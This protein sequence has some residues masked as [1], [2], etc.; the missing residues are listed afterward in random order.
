MHL[1]LLV[2][3]IVG[4]P[5]YV[6][7]AIG[8]FWTG[9]W[10]W[11]DVLITVVLFLFLIRHLGREFFD[12]LG[13]VLGLLARILSRA[14]RFSKRFGIE[15]ASDE[16]LEK[17]FRGR[18][19]LVEREK[20][21]TDRQLFLRALAL[22]LVL[23]SC[24]GLSQS[25]RHVDPAALVA[26]YPD[27]QDKPVTKQTLYEPHIWRVHF[28]PE[29]LGPTQDLYEIVGMSPP[30]DIPNPPPMPRKRPPDL[31]KSKEAKISS[32]RKVA[33]RS[34]NTP[35]DRVVPPSQTPFGI[36]DPIQQPELGI[37][38]FPAQECR[39]PFFFFLTKREAAQLC[40]NTLEPRR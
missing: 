16:D 23:S 9:G 15:L 8:K 1:A 2:G 17:A 5:I 36:R 6:Y 25:S 22:T 20:R 26:H 18:R 4:S 33:G 10:A 27:P 7:K 38:P 13:R 32:K 21:T 31:S 39:P 19:Y 11:D 35:P 12:N 14:A 29:P 28:S 30:S 34:R 3:F 24:F 40:N 37:Y